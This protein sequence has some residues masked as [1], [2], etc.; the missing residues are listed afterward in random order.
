MK[1]IIYYSHGMWE[2]IGSAVREQLLKANLPIVSC[3]LQPLDFGENVV[4]NLEP[5]ILTMFKQILAALKASKADTIFFCEH[6]VLYHPSHF[7]FE[8][9]SRDKFY[10]NVNVWRW[11]Y[12]TMRAVTWNTVRSLSGMCCDRELAIKHYEERV[13]FVE[14]N[15]WTTIY[16]FEPGTKKIRQ[17]GI[18]DDDFEDWKSELPLIDIRH[19]GTITPRKCHTTS[20]SNKEYIDSFVKIRLDQVPGWDYKHLQTICPTTT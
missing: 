1:G 5:S 6:D 19:Y 17:G 16:G 18:T 11:Y 10:Y 8:L 2:P 20:F 7:E 13:K 3:S 4:L 9:P 12:P 14:K 15:G